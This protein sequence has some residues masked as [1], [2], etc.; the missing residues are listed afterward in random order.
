MIEKLKWPPSIKESAMRIA[1]RQIDYIDSCRTYHLP[2]II[3]QT[4]QLCD[5]SGFVIW[6][7]YNGPHKNVTK[8]NEIM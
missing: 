4:D 3:G 7:I 6:S 2:P 5:V 8:S 1:S